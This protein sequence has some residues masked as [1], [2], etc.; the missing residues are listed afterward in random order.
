VLSQFTGTSLRTIEDEVVDPNEQYNF[1]YFVSMRKLME[2]VDDDKLSKEEVNK[3]A[4]SLKEIAKDLEHPAYFYIEDLVNTLEDKK[5][6]K[7][8]IAYLALANGLKVD[9]F[10]NVFGINPYDVNISNYSNL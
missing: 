6:T 7:I 5:P 4:S 8:S 3:Y 9:E 10:A 1:N 2:Q